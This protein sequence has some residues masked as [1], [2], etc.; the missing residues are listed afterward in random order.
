MYMYMYI[1]I[2]RDIWIYRDIYIYRDVVIYRDIQGYILDPLCPN[3]P[4]PPNPAFAQRPTMKIGSPMLLK[5]PTELLVFCHAPIGLQY[6]QYNM[7]CT[8]PQIHNGRWCHHGRSPK[9]AFILC[10]LY[11]WAPESS[12]KESQGGISIVRSNRFEILAGAGVIIERVP[13]WNL[14]CVFQSI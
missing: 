14:D 8:A 4:G 5:A 3:S 12:R 13:R 2:Y 11:E 1:Y 10:F 9:V 7:Y 6:M